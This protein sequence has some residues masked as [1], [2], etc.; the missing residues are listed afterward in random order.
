M[1]NLVDKRPPNQPSTM[2]ALSVLRICCALWA[3]SG[4]VAP[5]AGQSEM[6]R[7]RGESFYR[8]VSSNTMGHG[9]LWLTLT[10][11]GHVWDDVP[12]AGRSEGFWVSNLRAFPET[13]VSAGIFDVA[14]LS[15]ESRIIANGRVVPGWVSTDLKLTWPNNKNLRVF[16][17]GIDAK[18]LNNRLNSAP[19]LGGYIGF[20]PEGYVAKGG[21]FEGRCLFDVDLITNITALPLRAL[22]NIGFR[23]PL[24]EQYTGNYQFL[25]DAGIVYS[26][27]DY[28][29]YAA[30]SIEAFNNITGPKVFTQGTKKFLV[31]FS[32]NPMYLV[33]GG[34]VK[35]KNGTTLSF[36][37]PLLTSMNVE[38]KMSKAD[39]SYLD[40]RDSIARTRFPYE[41]S[42]NIRD[43][44]DP[45]FVKWKIVASLSFPLRYAMTGAEMMRNFLLLKNTKRQNRIDIDNRL[46]NFEQSTTVEPEDDDSKRLEE[47]RKRKEEMVKEEE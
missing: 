14:M 19:S 41:V 1:K 38:S 35:Y 40:R 4:L 27:Y 46:R 5:A 9:N 22:F 21:V 8:C 32:E 24:V 10:S 28:D 6:K 33:L 31:W 36:S 42:H 2:A 16:G 26:G 3:C 47:I 29:F 20:M 34:N 18:Y 15:V 44:F 13:R 30:Y 25:G 12:L 17:F 23:Q 11:V 37:V 39:Q 7:E 45:W 43:P